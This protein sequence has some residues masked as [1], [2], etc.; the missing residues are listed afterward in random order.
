MLYSASR[1]PRHSN[2][3]IVKLTAWVV[4]E[5]AAR[6]AIRIRALVSENV[7]QPLVHVLSTELRRP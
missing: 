2:M 7:L 4:S 5:I 3:D 6:N 1:T